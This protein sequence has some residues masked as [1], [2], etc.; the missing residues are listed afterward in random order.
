M[1]KVRNRYIIFGF[2]GLFVILS[3]LTN[4]TKQEYIHFSEKQSGLS[5]PDNKEIERKNF[6]IFSTYAPKV[7]NEYGIVHLG[8]MTN[9][10][11]ISEG[12]YDYPRWLKFFD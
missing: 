7:H 2:L 9:F 4:P 8:F 10:F 5:K 11:Q 3:I 12:Q 1:K 6:F